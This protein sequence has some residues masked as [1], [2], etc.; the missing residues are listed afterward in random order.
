MIYFENSNKLWT[1]REYD[2]NNN[3]IFFENSE[4]YW[5]GHK[6]DNAGNEIYYI[7]SIEK[8]NQL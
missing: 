4:G 5:S 7:N 3:E 1:K 6:F 8:R 2:K